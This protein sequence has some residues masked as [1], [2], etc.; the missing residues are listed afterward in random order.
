MTNGAASIANITSSDSI[1]CPGG[2]TSLTVSGGSHFIWNTGDTTQSINV[3]PN[4]TTNYSITVIDSN[5]CSQNIQYIQYVSGIQTLTINS[6]ND[7]VCY[8]GS[9]ILHA[10]GANSYHWL[11]GGFGANHS[12]NPTNQTTYLVIGTNINGCSDTASILINTYLT[13]F[14]NILPLNP[15]TCEGSNIVLIAIGGVTFNWIGGGSSSTHLYSP[16]SPTTYSVVATNSLGCIDT[17][18]AFVNVLTLPNVQLTSTVDTICQGNSVILTASGANN[19]SA[20]WLQNGNSSCTISPSTTQNYSVTGT[21]VNGC[22]KSVTKHITV[23]SSNFSVAFSI[24][25]SQIITANTP[26][27]FNNTT[28]NPSLYTFYWNYGDGNIVQNNNPSVFHTYTN[29]GNFDVILVAIKNSTG[30][31]DTL[32][33]LGYVFVSGG[34]ACPVT[35]N[36]TAN[37]TATCPGDSLLLQASTGTNYTYMWR[38]NSVDISSATSVNYYAK[39]SGNYSVTISDGNCSVTSANQT[40]NFYSVPTTPTIQATGSLNLCSGGIITLSTNSGYNSYNWSNN[41]NTQSI[42][43]TQSGVYTVIVNN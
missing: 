32:Y 43:I 17:A 9:I 12:V 14:V 40:I 19:Y 8:G 4:I 31:S 37:A 10:S 2:Y 38:K 26:S 41:G 29:N 21:D 33:R 34:V 42:N 3:S 39:N 35:A 23:N 30:C 7:S 16:I 28:V 27:Q 24:V 5:N 13:S 11:D 1:I 22:S 6:S 36:I 15:Q 25:G 20:S 18:G